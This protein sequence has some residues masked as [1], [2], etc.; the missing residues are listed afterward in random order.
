MNGLLDT[1]IVDVLTAADNFKMRGHPMNLKTP[2]LM[3]VNV[4]FSNRVD[5]IW[6]PLPNDKSLTSVASFK[7]GVLPTVQVACGSFCC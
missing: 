6:K 4:I 1:E 2:L 5:N 3:Q 7:S